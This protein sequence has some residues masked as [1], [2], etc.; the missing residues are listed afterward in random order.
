MDPFQKDRIPLWSGSV[1]KRI[2]S[3]P[4]PTSPFIG[5]NAK[6]KTTDPN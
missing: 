1:I 3:I 5:F 4:F 6:A 2:A